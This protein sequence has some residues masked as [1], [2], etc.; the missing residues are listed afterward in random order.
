M[1]FADAGETDEQPGLDVM[2]MVDVVFIL[3]AF[4]VLTARFTG[5]ER[6][7]H[8]GQTDLRP[9]TGAAAQDLPTEVLVQ[10]RPSGEGVGLTVG[11][12]QLPTNGFAQLTETL[13]RLDL[14]QLSV[15]I[16][17]HGAVSVQEVAEVMDAVLASPMSR[18]SLARLDP[19]GV[20]GG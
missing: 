4:F 15:V 12:T 18:V 16:A 20:G 8:V 2:P 6:D 9:P 14:P 19:E 3:L 10:V 11:Q 5:G 17:A 1:K 13:N 7:L